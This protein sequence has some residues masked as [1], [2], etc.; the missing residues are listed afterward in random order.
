MAVSVAVDTRAAR[1]W[2]GRRWF[3]PGPQL[4]ICLSGGK[5]RLSDLSDAELVEVA[6]AARRQTSWAQA[7][8]LAAIAEL[9]QR[10]RH[11]EDE[12]DAPRILSAHESVVEEVAA[13]LTV[14][15][16]TAAALVHLAERL[17]D[18]L[19]STMHALEA[20]HIDLPRARIICDATDNLSSDLVKRVESAV[21]DKASEQTT[22]QLRRRTR[23][24]LHRIAPAEFEER[25][26][27]TV[28]Q[29]RIEVWDDPAGTAGL[30]LL[31]LPAEDA[32]AIHNKITAVAHSIRADGD[33]RT[34]DNLR[35]DLAVRLLRGDRLPEAVHALVTA[36]VPD[37]TSAAPSPA[38][39]DPSVSPP[40][41]NDEALTEVAHAVDRELTHV[42]NHARATGRLEAL[43]LL[44]ARAV[45]DMH[46]SLHTR[47]DAEC[48]P[49]HSGHGHSAYRPPA[50]MRKSVEAR[51]A[52]CVFPTCNVR[53]SRCD[54]D[55]TVPYGRGATCACN[56][57]PL[58]RRH[59]RAK[60]SPGWHLTHLL[61]GLLIWTTP[62][63]TW[64]IV[65]P[66][67]Q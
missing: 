33:G 34:L 37:S 19:P 29:R 4:A 45:Q 28:A 27:E 58:C 31:D 16:N 42:L 50:A 39:A 25:K 32:H 43:P 13:A 55:H 64:H 66:E 38:S 30:A 3:P 54:L 61:P 56:L 24:I 8:E 10:R 5:D 11:D 22:G 49:A 41:A 23:R 51:H 65:R 59:H 9:A 40:A 17:A 63:G 60:Q 1:E 18:D 20:G 6:A 62:S 2:E 53:S 14:T 12:T 52:T 67:R 46:R 48:R 36:P 15:G 7:R 26:R 47:R 44:T 35:A 21:L 57:A